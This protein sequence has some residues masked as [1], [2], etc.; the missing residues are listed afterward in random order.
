MIRSLYSAASGMSAQQMNIDNIANNLANV[1]TNGF[2]MRRT[3]FQDLLYQSFVQPGAAAGSQTTVP[4]GLQIGLGTRPAANEII[5]SQ[6]NF[7]QTSNPLDVVIQGKGFFQ[8]RRPTG[9]VAYTRDGEFQ[10]DRDGNI[11]T[12]NGDPLEP[13]ITIP[14]ES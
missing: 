7:Q 3:Q 4:S 1:N 13:Q 12:A 8:I 2:K 10:L 14:S 9:E 6:G 5:F 11:V